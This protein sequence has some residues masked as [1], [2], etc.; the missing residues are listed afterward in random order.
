MQTASSMSSAPTEMPAVH[1]F[2][3]APYGVDRR[4]HL[5][6]S[7]KRRA[8][9]CGCGGTTTTA[10]GGGG[11]TSGARSCLRGTRGQ[12]SV[13]SGQADAG[14]LPGFCRVF[15]SFTRSCRG[16]PTDRP[17]LAS[18]DKQ[19][20][21]PV[22]LMAST[23]GMITFRR[24]SQQG[25]SATLAEEA[26]QELEHVDEVQIEAERA[27]HRRPWRHIR[28]RATCWYSFLRRCVSQAVRPAKISTPRIEI[29]SARPRRLQEHVD[30]HRH[31]NT[32]HA[33]DKE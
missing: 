12:V 2:P 25:N 20:K 6:V 33:H 30:Q 18:V 27:H 29:A 5:E 16:N 1:R 15:K 4:W 22:R 11:M 9:A 28:C 17:V 10:T 14:Q 21:C 7:A 26:Q 32:D 19:R 13:T 8:A 23:P 24:K 3:Q 31:E